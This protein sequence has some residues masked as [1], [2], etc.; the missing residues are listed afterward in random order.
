MDKPARTMETAT[1]T[2]AIHGLNRKNPP[3]LTP[4]PHLILDNHHYYFP[5]AFEPW[6]SGRKK[7]FRQRGKGHTKSLENLKHWLQK[8]DLTW[9]HREVVFI[10]D[11][12]ADA[13]AL[14]ASLVA[15]GLVEYKEKE[16]LFKLTKQGKQTL[17]VFGGDFFDKGPSN[18]E[19]LLAL[20]AFIS[21]GA[22]IRLL[23]GNHDIRVLFGMYQAGKVNDLKNSHFFVRMGAKALPFVKEIYCRYFDKTHAKELLSDKKALQQLM[24]HE[25]WEKK[26]PELAKDALS[27]QAIANELR[28]IAKKSEAFVEQCDAHD[29]RPAEVLWATQKWQ[30]LFLSQNGEFNWFYKKMRLATRQGSFLF[31]HAGFD[32]AA[33]KI[34]EEHGVGR[35]NKLF[36]KQLRLSPFDFYYGEIANIIRTKY[37]TVDKP[38]TN[39]G[40]KC[41]H[42]AGIHVIVHGHRNL[43]SGQRI[44]MRKDIMHIEC[45]VTMDS[46]SRKKEGLKGAGAGATLIKLDRKILG[47]STDYPKIKVFEPD[48]LD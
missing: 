21:S 45:D 9:P 14:I 37:R 32:D 3:L 17:F 23:A 13:D 36:R 47:I 30:S 27:S 29:I 48:R 34:F 41:M 40:A 1:I 11:L 46:G 16:S 19:L 39:V 6:L 25:H 20:K 5:V 33:A 38:L 26:F 12:H 42:R 31:V 4:Q 10:S 18:L 2:I 8:Y 15:T 28:K 7:A 22:N 44:A 35:V 43:H 24:P